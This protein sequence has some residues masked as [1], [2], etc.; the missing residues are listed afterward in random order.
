MWFIYFL[1]FCLSG[2]FDHI[3]SAYG[4]WLIL[5]KNCSCKNISVTIHMTSWLEMERYWLFSIPIPYQ[6]QLSI[7]YTDQYRPMSHAGDTGTDRHW[8][9]SVFY[10]YNTDKYRSVF[11]NT[12][13]FLKFRSVYISIGIILH[14]PKFVSFENIFLLL[15]ELIFCCCCLLLVQYLFDFPLVKETSSY[16][17]MSSRCIRWFSYIFKMHFCNR[18]ILLSDA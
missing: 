14:F 4:I 13:R 8:Y 3:P 7:H 15:I 10:F 12:D 11:W 2:F 16:S 5:N 1:F 9:R 17:W 6:L 18:F